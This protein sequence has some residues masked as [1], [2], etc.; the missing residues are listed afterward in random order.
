MI[1]IGSS[2]STESRMNLGLTEKMVG[3]DNKV[4]GQNCPR[5]VWGW[6]LIEKG[7]FFL[8]CFVL[9]YLWDF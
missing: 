3:H 8:F 1:F 5:W 2:V 4:P 6:I 7:S 9:G